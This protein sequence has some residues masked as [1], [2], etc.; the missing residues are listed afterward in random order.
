[1]ITAMATVMLH[2]KA[3]AALCATANAATD[4]VVQ[5]ISYNQ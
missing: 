1:M 4:A 2:A 3:R 5:L